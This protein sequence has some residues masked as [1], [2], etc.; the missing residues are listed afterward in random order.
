MR[1]GSVP[2]LSTVAA[3]A[4]ARA[5]QASEERPPS[6]TPSTTSLSRPSLYAAAEARGGQEAAVAALAGATSPVPPRTAARPA[7]R[8]AVKTRI[9]EPPKFRPTPL[10]YSGPP[11]KAP[12][13]RAGF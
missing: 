9:D 7:V 13:D 1:D 12:T 3:H 6:V 11:A 4:P 2:W 5:S 10:F 8:T